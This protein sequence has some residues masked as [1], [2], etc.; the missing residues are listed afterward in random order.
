[1]LGPAPFPEPAPIPRPT[2]PSPVRKRGVPLWA[3][4]LIG[5]L[6]SFALLIGLAIFLFLKFGWSTFSDQA[7][8]AM[9][10]QS[11]IQ[12]CIGHIENASLDFT[13]TNS[14]S[15]ENAFAFRVTGPAGSG[16]VTAVFTTVDA[17]NERI[18][19]GELKMTD[20][21]KFALQG[22]NDEESEDDAPAE[23]GCPRS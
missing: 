13:R 1:M 5:V 21:R 12:R 16:L 8:V 23:S 22:A 18:D 19:E 20:G 10:E 11:I 14:D 9:N 4:I 3:G 7:I 15:R 2:P 6:G 17:D